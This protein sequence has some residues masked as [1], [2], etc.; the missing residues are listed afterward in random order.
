MVDDRSGQRGFSIVELMIVL[1]LNSTITAITFGSF[2]APKHHRRRGH[3]RG[4]WQLG[5]AR[6]TAINQRQPVEVR[7]T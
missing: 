6:K 4:R 2:L 1:T 7:A 3:A 5:S